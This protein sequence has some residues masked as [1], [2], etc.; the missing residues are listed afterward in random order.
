VK[1][2]HFNKYD[3]VKTYNVVTNQ[4]VIQT[5]KKSKYFKVNLGMAVTMEKNGERIISDK[6]QFSISYNFQYKTTI[7]A[8]GNV[9]NIRFY[10]DYGIHEDILAI[11]Y[12]LEEFLFDYD[13]DFIAHKGVDA[14]IGYLLKEVDD[15][16]HEK[17]QKDKEKAEE[18]NQKIGSPD[19]L[20]I[21][22][23]AVTYEDIQ[24]YMKTKR[25]I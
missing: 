16:Y 3:M 14:Y 25:K 4:K 8:Q 13:Q 18:K 20:T 11:Y 6:D 22:P 23:G 12:D 7:Y 21:N 2:A 19:K 24:A 5:I 9:G 15:R 10:L 1:I 17:V